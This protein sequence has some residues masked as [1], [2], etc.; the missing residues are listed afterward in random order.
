MRWSQK[1]AYG[2]SGCIASGVS[3]MLKYRSKTLP[4]GFFAIAIVMCELALPALAIPPARI[5][6][7]G[8]AGS[9]LEESN[10]LTEIDSYEGNKLLYLR[11]G[12][13]YCRQGDNT[14]NRTH[15]YCGDQYSHYKH[16]SWP[17]LGLGLGFL[18]ELGNS[19]D[20]GHN[21]G[22]AHVQWCQNRYLSYNLR[23]DTFAG[24]DGHRHRCRGLN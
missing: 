16:Y 2:Q 14:Y 3:K 1:K 17:Y 11:H 7:V 9:N 4:V 12:N 5:A 24:Y 15:R 10:L 20:N 22:D 23:T 18:Y 8:N 21:G 19:R 6:A 13:Y